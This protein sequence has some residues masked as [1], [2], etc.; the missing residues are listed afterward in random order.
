M[1]SLLLVLMAFVGYLVAYHTYGK[2]LSGK[3]FRL[4]ASNRMP[5]RDF[6]DGVDYVP[7]KKHIVF[8]HHFTTIA[9]LGPIVGPAIGVIWGW[10]PALAWVFLGSIL[11]GAVHDFSTMVISARNQGRTIGDLTGG[12]IGPGARYALQFIM[13]ILLFIVLSVFAL[14]VATLFML[15]PEAVIPV[16]MQIPIAIWLGLQIRKG[17][18]DLLYSILALLMMYGSI[19]L[20]V[21]FPV[22]LASWS[23]IDG[24]ASSAGFQL[25]NTVTVIWCVL[26]FIYVFIASTLPVQRLLQP[27]DYINSHQ[28]FVALFLI[29]LGIIVARPVLSAPAINAV[30]FLPGND[31]PDMMPLLFIIIACGAI[32]GFHSIAGSGTTVKQISSEPDTFPIGYGG[33]I[34]EGFLAVLVIVCVAGGLGLGLER[35]GVLFTGR[36]AFMHYYSSWS[37][38]NS[39]IGGKLASFIVGA[40]NLLDSIGIPLWLGK[41]M[42]AVFIVSFANTTLDSAAR[43][44]RLSLQE[45]FRSKENNKVT[46][47]FDNRYVATFFVVLLAAIMTFLKPGGQGA[48]VLWPLFGS[49]NQLLAALGLAVVSVYLYQKGKNYWVALLPMFF[50]LI[51]TIWSMLE[52]L[53]GFI[54][55]RDYLLTCLSVIIL[56]LA[57]WLFVAGF[58]S[59]LRRTGISV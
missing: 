40:A 12:I 48:L 26:L 27:R 46:P 35:D 8:G 1:N 50:V 36:D 11:M 5:A 42:I 6:E 25:S 22:D 15:Y 21:Y 9:G 55:S 13:Q 2:Y 41:P 47:P 20:G 10:L 32:S 51:M 18:S 39:G 7:T 33:M 3:L 43:M 31:V 4:S 24:F 17:R 34:T 14:I 56:I 57:L 58:R 54:N 45:L 23:V 53:S 37:A 30:A 59:F 19:I 49:L 16:W 28:L 44:Q 52:G 29:L 38:A